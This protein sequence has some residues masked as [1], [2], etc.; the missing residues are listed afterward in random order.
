M[1]KSAT[2][3]VPAVAVDGDTLQDG[4]VSGSRGGAGDAGGKTGAKS[5]PKRRKADCMLDYVKERVKR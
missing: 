3:S 4:S 5:G 1:S 2:K